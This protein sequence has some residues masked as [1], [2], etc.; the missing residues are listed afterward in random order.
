MKV[1][2]QARIRFSVGKYNEELVCNVVP[3][4]EFHLLLRRP[5]QF[6]IDVVHQGRSNKYTFVIEGKKYEL[7]PFAPYQVS[8]QYLVMKEASGKNK[9]Y[10][11][12]RS[13]IVQKEESTLA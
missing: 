10:R 1:L 11:G 9:N 4:L 13:T 5:W 12:K 3:M 2:K 8:E 7:A 6:D